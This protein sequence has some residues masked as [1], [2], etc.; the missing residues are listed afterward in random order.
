MK[1]KRSEESYKR[2]PFINGF[3]D[4]LRCLLNPPVLQLATF[5][6]TPYFYYHGSFGKATLSRGNPTWYQ[7][8][9]EN[10]EAEGLTEL[11]LLER[12]KSESVDWYDDRRDVEEFKLM[13]EETLFLVYALGCL[14]I[15]DKGIQVTVDQLWDNF[16]TDKDFARRYAVYHYY[17]SK[18]M[19]P[20]SGLLFGYDFVLYKSGPRFRHSDFGVIILDRDEI[21]EVDLLTA[22]MRVAGQVR[23]KLI[24]CY[25]TSPE[26]T[27]KIDC[28]KHFQIHPIIGSRFV[29]QQ[30]RE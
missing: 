19:T 14:K 30:N 25:V 28:L 21:G 10:R 2:L 7:R 6:T 4:R 23:K 3:V 12:F 29:P 26:D 24:L 1:K 27:S 11:R 20:R 22:R 9:Y 17:R 5:T 15:E 8:H 16:R 18:G 13:P